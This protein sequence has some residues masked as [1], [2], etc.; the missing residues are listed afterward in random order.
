MRDDDARH[1]A[2]RLERGDSGVADHADAFPLRWQQQRAL[3]DGPEARVIVSEAV[4]QQ[5]GGLGEIGHADS[6]ERDL[7]YTI[8]DTR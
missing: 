5:R 4:A 6:V 2:T 1:A 7:V 3:R 8:N